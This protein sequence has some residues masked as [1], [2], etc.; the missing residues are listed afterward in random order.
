MHQGKSNVAIITAASDP[1]DAEEN[2]KYYVDLFN[3][4]K[5]GNFRYFAF[6]YLHKFSD[7]FVL[8]GLKLVLNLHS[9]IKY[10]NHSL[11]RC[12]LGSNR[13]G[14]HKKCR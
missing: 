2:G 11:F 12:V 8:M 5:A 13:F 10:P 9:K 14:P 1:S 6:I 4:N 3:K 7:Y